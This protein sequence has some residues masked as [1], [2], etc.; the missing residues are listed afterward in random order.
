MRKRWSLAL[1]VIVIMSIVLLYG[2]GTG[3]EETTPHATSKLS[4]E[5]M[6]EL[7]TQLLETGSVYVPDQ[8]VASELVGFEVTIPSHVPDG[9]KPVEF[10][11]GPFHVHT[12]GNVVLTRVP[13]TTF[14]A[15][16]INLTS[17]SVAANNDLDDDLMVDI[18]YSQTGST[19]FAQEP[20][21]VISQMLFDHNVS[22]G[23]EP[24]QIGNYPG[25]RVF[26]THKDK[27]IVMLS[28]RDGTKVCVVA[29][30][31]G[32]SLD[33]VTLMRVAVSLQG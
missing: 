31:L 13:E 29:A 16:P 11:G 6:E 2:C 19:A 30:R 21:V 28:W 32:D 27:T 14:A 7:K 3:A 18:V 8:Y 20:S 9:F 26:Q 12:W 17:R 25:Y 4:T 5:A 10:T 33:E 15:K 1:A 24:T 23:W 22:E